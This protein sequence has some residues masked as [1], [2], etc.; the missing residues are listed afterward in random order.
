MASAIPA[1]E[2]ISNLASA[3]QSM[4][5]ANEAYENWRHEY[6]N[7]EASLRA[8]MERHAS[9]QAEEKKRQQDIK[10]GQKNVTAANAALAAFYR[11]AAA[12]LDAGYAS[13]A[14]LPASP[15][16][17]G[18]PFKKRYTKEEKK[19]MSPELKKA[20]KQFKDAAAAIRKANRTPEEQEVINARVAKMVA[21][22]RAAKM[23]TSVDGSEAEGAIATA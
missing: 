23:Q 12:P 20:R 4:E 9:L 7:N 10:E 14:E 17:P 6:Q 11:S 1:S 19:A 2:L 5:A 21:A 15:Q 3:Q 13:P 16:I 8:A 18:T 22:R